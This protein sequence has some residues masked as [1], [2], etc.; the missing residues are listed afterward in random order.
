MIFNKY[1]VSA[2]KMSSRQKRTSP[3]LT[4]KIFERAKRAEYVRQGILHDM[5]ARTAAKA[6]ALAGLVPDS[7]K[8]R[9]TIGLLAKRGYKPARLIS[10][11]HQEYELL[12]P[13]KRLTPTKRS[14]SK[15]STP[16]KSPKRVK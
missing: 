3:R 4:T 10:Y 7:D 1:K 13:P 14:P 16:R 9:R 5:N 11:H 2:T 12:H 15:R 6:L 8:A